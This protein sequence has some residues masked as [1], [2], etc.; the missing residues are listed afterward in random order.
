MTPTMRALLEETSLKGWTLD[1]VFR[2]HEDHATGAGAHCDYCGARIVWA[3]RLLHAPVRAGAGDHYLEAA[4]PIEVIV[5]S[6]CVNSF[7]DDVDGKASIA[8]LRAAWK[9]R[10]RYFWKRLKHTTAI[11]GPHRNTNS[12]WA[13]IGDTLLDTGSWEYSR[14]RF[15]SADDAKAYV[16]A[17]VLRHRGRR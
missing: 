2:V 5:G 6:E 1:R 3:F 11:V 12:W 8:F 15:R 4:K 17:Y 10:R 14:R 9:Q 7:I 13:A 16:S